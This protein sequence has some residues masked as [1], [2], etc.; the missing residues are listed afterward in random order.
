MCYV[1]FSM[2]FIINIAAGITQNFF[3]YTGKEEGKRR[4]ECSCVL[5]PLPVCVFLPSPHGRP[6]F[7]QYAPSSAAPPAPAGGVSLWSGAWRRREPRPGL[8]GNLFAPCPPNQCPYAAWWAREEE[9]GRHG[10]Q[11]SVKQKKKGWGRKKIILT[12]CVHAYLC[13]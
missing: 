11:P 4:M 7:P 9:A 13:K 8:H 3:T 2:S 5:P 10:R 12:T 1:Y 6:S